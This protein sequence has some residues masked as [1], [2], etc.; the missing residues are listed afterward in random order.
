MNL[1]DATNDFFSSNNIEIILRVKN[2]RHIDENP[3]RK[4]AS[5]SDEDIQNRDVA[6]AY[7]TTSVGSSCKPAVRMRRYPSEAWKGLQSMFVAVFEALEAI[8]I[9]RQS[10]Q[11]EKGKKILECSNGILEL[12]NKLEST[13]NSVSRV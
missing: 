4:A 6:L 2:L 7:I 10:I 8:L 11:F 5:M 9:R 1:L 12:I 3:A 13:D